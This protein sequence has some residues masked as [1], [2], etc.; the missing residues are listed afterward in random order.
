VPDTTVIPVR[1]P[2]TADVPAHVGTRRASL[3]RM[4]AE[5]FVWLMPTTEDAAVLQTQIERG[6]SMFGS[7]SFPPHVTM[8]SEPAVTKLAAVGSLRQLPLSL[9]LTEL[10][11]GK[12]YF[13][14][15]YLE[16][17]DDT[18][19]CDLQARCV[20]TLGG[21]VPG[22]YPPHLSIAYGVL[23]SDQRAAAATLV[24]LPLV[25]TFDRLELWTS[26]GPVSSWRKLA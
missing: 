5:L 20:A 12:D 16:A 2:T 14:G 11:F 22:Q 26:N 19:L 9:R 4:A 21:T 7:P 3:A 17:A 24:E 8:C 13:H 10:R 6:A 1:E 23:S 18:P 25:V 15:C